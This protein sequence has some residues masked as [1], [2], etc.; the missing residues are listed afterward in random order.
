MQAASSAFSKVGQKGKKK[1]WIA[2]SL[3]GSKAK[4]CSCQ[5][6]MA[7]WEVSRGG[8]GAFSMQQDHVDL[9]EAHLAKQRLMVAL[10]LKKL[11]LSKNKDG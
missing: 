1:K 11:W 3:G 10:N 9:H 2:F 7:L 5:N 8:Q 4:G 6:A